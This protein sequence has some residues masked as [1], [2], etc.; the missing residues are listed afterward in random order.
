M[1]SHRARRTQVN[2]EKVS[3][4]NSQKS[5][6]QLAHAELQDP[7]GF[8]WNERHDHLCFETAYMIARAKGTGNDMNCRSQYMIYQE[9]THHTAHASPLRFFALPFL[10]LTRLPLL[11][12]IRSLWF[13]VIPHEG[14]FIR[15]LKRLAGRGIEPVVK[16][17][18]NVGVPAFSR[19]RRR[20]RGD[21]MPPR[22]REIEH[23]ASFEMNHV[24]LARFRETREP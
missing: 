22:R 12:N 6:C 14:I 24:W 16:R 11:Y 21:F 2:N 3:E 10:I 20:S 15:L 13:E 8:V 18:V 1:R 9:R 4:P 7:A 5:H 19:A 17:H 23:L